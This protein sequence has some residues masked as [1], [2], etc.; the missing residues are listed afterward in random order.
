MLP[1]LPYRD[2]RPR[3][4]LAAFDPSGA[5]SRGAAP[6]PAPGLVEE[7][8][9][10]TRVTDYPG[11]SRR[12]VHRELARCRRLSR[13]RRVV[14][15]HC[16]AV[17]DTQGFRT[18]AIMVT[19]TYRPGVEYD[20]RQV[21]R[22]IDQEVKWAARRG[23]RLKYQWVIELQERGAPH[24]HV[25]F[26]VPHKFRLRKPDE[27]GTWPHGMSRI[28]LA[29][30]AVG[31]LVKYT[32]KGDEDSAFPRGARLFGCGGE[33]CARHPAHRAG[34]PR[35]LHAVATPTSKVYRVPAIGWVERDTG[36]VHQS[37]F[38]LAFESYIGGVRLVVTKR[39]SQ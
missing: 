25:L 37:P 23:V 31:Y 28:G 1:E 18:D 4:D 15:A 19:L 39:E 35:W 16:E 12:D 21:S 22:F 3:P 27:A 17:R 33:P 11:K 26:W 32:T 20:K 38:T 30:K 7:E 10:T 36:A 34:L 8:T 5:G 6:A 2:A 24:Y 9:S 13:M 14:V 29:R